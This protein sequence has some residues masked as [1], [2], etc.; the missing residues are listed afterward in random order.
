MTRRIWILHLSQ[1]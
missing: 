1:T